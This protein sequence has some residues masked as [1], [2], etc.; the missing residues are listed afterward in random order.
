M[1]EPRHISIVE[2][3]VRVGRGYGVPLALATQ[4]LVDLARNVKALL[5]S[6][7]LLI[8]MPSTSLEYWREVRKVAKVGW[9][10]VE[11][12]RSLGRGYALV[13]MAPDPRSI[14]VKLEQS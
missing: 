5:D 10:R 2:E 3:L 12:M 8:V 9:E 6:I 14:I 1:R 7:G 13:R 11:R 4:T